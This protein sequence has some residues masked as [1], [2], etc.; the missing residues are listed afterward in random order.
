[1]TYSN[2]NLA[3]Y[4]TFQLKEVCKYLDIKTEI[5]LSS[6]IEMDNALKAKEF[7]EEYGS[8]HR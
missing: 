8:F 6:E 1:M 7:T 4:L 5:L 2:D 3:R